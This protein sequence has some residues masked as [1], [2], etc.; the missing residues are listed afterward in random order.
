MCTFLFCLCLVTA[1]L[2]CG[3]TSCW[4]CA[5]SHGGS[6]VWGGQQWDGRCQ[7]GAYATHVAFFSHE[8]ARSQTCYSHVSTY[9]TMQA[10]GGRRRREREEKDLHKSNEIVKPRV[11]NEHVQ[12]ARR[13]QFCAD[14]NYG[15]TFLCVCVCVCVCVRVRACVRVCTC[16]CVCV[17]QTSRSPC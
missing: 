8:H 2:C 10:E 17:V 4:M 13:S 16:V 5:C 9:V 15:M 7:V 12:T 6:G 3:S 14:C 1:Q 11:K